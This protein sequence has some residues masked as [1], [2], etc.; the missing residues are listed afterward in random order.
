MQ[1]CWPIPWIPMWSSILFILNGRNIK[2]SSL[3]DEICCIFRI[4]SKNCTNAC[5]SG[6]VIIL[7]QVKIMKRWSIS[8]LLWLFVRS[9]LVV[10]LQ[11]YNFFWY[12]IQIMIKCEYT[13]VCISLVRDAKFRWLWSGRVCY[14]FT[15]GVELASLSFMSAQ[16]DRP[17][18][19]GYIKM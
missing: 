5:E 2:W 8:F 16:R 19:S 3:E 6:L 15:C 14:Y 4:L 10:K 1:S 7:I 12:P 17:P 11:F 18:I 13:S 9:K